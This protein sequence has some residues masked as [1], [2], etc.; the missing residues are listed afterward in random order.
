MEYKKG[1]KTKHAKII[2]ELLKGGGKQYEDKRR[3]V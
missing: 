2:S 3:S 1:K